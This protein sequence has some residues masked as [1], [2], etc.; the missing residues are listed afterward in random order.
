M[1]F[2]LVFLYKVGVLLLDI[3]N[4]YCICVRL[5]F[6]YCVFVFYYVLLSYFSEDYD[7]I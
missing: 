4:F 5:L 1:Y 2:L 3:V 6:E 7:R